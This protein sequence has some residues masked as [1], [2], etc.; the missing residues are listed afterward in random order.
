MSWR[1]SVCLMKIQAGRPLAMQMLYR[2]IN[3]AGI[4]RVL[5]PSLT[6]LT[7]V[8]AALWGKVWA[9]QIVWGSL[10]APAHLVY[11]PTTP[12]RGEVGRQG[13]AASVVCLDPAGLVTSPS[14]PSEGEAGRLVER[15][16]VLANI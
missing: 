5:D 9:S 6:T 7:Q 8:G 10:S 12:Q 2:E 15:R 14:T 4:Q 16:Q 11:P 3:S 1:L 13:W